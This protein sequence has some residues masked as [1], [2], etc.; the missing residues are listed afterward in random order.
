MRSLFKRTFYLSWFVYFQ[1]SGAGPVGNLVVALLIVATGSLGGM[2]VTPGNSQTALN[3]INN[4]ITG[5]TNLP[6]YFSLCAQLA[7]ITHRCSQLVEAL[8]E[9]QVGICTV[10]CHSLYG[11]WMYVLFGYCDNSVREKDWRDRKRRTQAA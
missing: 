3:G 5:L 6:Q 10:C 4:L 2:P 8:D 1:S 11:W 7:G 9:L